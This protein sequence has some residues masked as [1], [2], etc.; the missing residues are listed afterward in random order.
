MAQLTTPAIARQLGVLFDDGS[1]IGLSDRQLIERFNHRRDEAAF[2]ALVAR[3]GPMVLGLCRQLLGD[4]HLA[5]DAFQAVFLVLARKAHSLRDPD[6]LGTWLYGV[7][8]RTARKARARMARQRI[9]EQGDVIDALTESAEPTAPPADQASLDRDQADVLHGE[10]DRLPGIFRSPIVLCYFEGLTLDEAARQLG[11][12]AGTLR[13]R[14][15]RAP[16]KAPP[17]LVRRGVVLPGAALDAISAPPSVSS[18]LCDLTASAALRFT[19]RLTITSTAT[20]LAQR[21]SAP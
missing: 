3:H 18:H 6:L 20:S 1:L 7:A 21:C 11:C 5:E 12:P 19:A 14:L 15:A 17:R 13:S 2:A 16:R 10:I 4:R 8:L 9:H